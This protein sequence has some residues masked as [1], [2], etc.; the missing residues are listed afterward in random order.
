MK[1]MRRV[2]MKIK[3]VSKL[4]ARWVKSEKPAK[5]ERKKKV[6]KLDSDFQDVVDAENI[7]S[8]YD[9]ENKLNEVI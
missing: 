9:S 7:E 5:K 4:G 3:K 2:N 1:T 8:F 6:V